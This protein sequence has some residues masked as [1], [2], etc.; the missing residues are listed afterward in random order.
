MQSLSTALA[1]GGGVDRKI[2]SL[3]YLQ[4]LKVEAQMRNM[5][6]TGKKEGLTTITITLNG[7]AG[8]I[9]KPTG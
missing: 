8:E 4:E 1:P 2:W 5:S 3:S 9:K 7:C 6:M